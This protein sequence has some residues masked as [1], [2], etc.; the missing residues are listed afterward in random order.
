MAEIL[1]RA[2]NN[3]HADPTKDRQGSYK[4]GMPVVVMDDGHIWGSKEGLPD[5]VVLKVP[6]VSKERV[7]KYFEPQVV[8]NGF[9]EDGITPHFDTYRRRLWRLRV[10]DLPAG[11]ITKFQT[12]GEITI[13]ASPDYTGPYDYTWSNVKGYF[14]NQ[15]TD[16]DET[17]NV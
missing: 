3:V 8:Q 14:R 4:R 15:E 16:L 10:D 2:K 12:D 7:M 13:K 11:A 9:E 5:F 1:I 6:M 17:A